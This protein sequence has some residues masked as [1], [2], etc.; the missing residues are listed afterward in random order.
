MQLLEAITNRKTLLIE[1]DKDWLEEFMFE[2]NRYQSKYGFM[3]IDM[4]IDI[5]SG[6]N[7]EFKI[8]RVC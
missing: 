4:I 8:I 3:T 1:L 7:N 2:N 6:K 5:A